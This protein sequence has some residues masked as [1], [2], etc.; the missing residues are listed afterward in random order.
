MSSLKKGIVMAAMAALLVGA[1]ATALAS[2]GGAP[3][4]ISLSATLPAATPV[5]VN[6]R[7]TALILLDYIPFVAQHLP[8]TTYLAPSA[9]LLKTARQAHMLIIH[10]TVPG[11]SGWLPGFTPARGEPVV[12]GYPDKYH[13]LGNIDKPTKLLPL[14]RQHHINTLIIAGA[15]TSGGVFFTTYE[16]LQQGLTVIIPENAVADFS[17]NQ[18]DLT[19]YELLNNEVYNNHVNNPNVTD[20]TIVTTVSDLSVAP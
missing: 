6:P 16:S 14:L 12:A 9:Q 15:T 18:S 20:K 4:A 17:S 13:A 5:K 3:Q 8:N 2:D 1:G 10:T 11:L 7:H 19:L